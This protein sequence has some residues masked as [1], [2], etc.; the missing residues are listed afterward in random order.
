[1]ETEI[2]FTFFEEINFQMYENQL[3]HAKRKAHRKIFKLPCA[4][5]LII[6]K[7]NLTKIAFV[8]S[9]HK[10]GLRTLLIITK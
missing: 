8:P 4:R 6:Q 2:F 7:C 5:I 3:I 10:K 1:M 9:L